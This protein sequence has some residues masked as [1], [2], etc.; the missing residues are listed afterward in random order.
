MGLSPTVPL[1]QLLQ[2]GI[3]QPGSRDRLDLLWW[4]AKVLPPRPPTATAVDGDLECSTAKDKDWAQA[5]H[6]AL[7][8]LHAAS[9]STERGNR[10]GAILVGL[11][12]RPLLGKSC[13]CCAASVGE[14]NLLR[15]KAEEEEGMEL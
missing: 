13:C 14:V 6:P 11:S 7:Y 10:H 15:R 3:E 9:M 12:L 2:S 1:S 8:Q 4:E 5:L